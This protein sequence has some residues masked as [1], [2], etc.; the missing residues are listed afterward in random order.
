MWRGVGW[1]RLKEIPF[2]AVEVVEDGDD[3]VGFVARD[4]EEFDV[5]GLHAAVVAVEVVGVEEEEDTAAGL[6]ADLVR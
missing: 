5:V 4:F 3:A 2:V 6:V 1:C